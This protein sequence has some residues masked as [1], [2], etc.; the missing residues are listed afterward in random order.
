MPYHPAIVCY[1]QTGHQPQSPSSFHDELVIAA[2][3]IATAA[4]PVPAISTT[5]AAATLTAAATAVAVA[6]LAELIQLGPMVASGL[7]PIDDRCG[8]V[9]PSVK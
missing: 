8:D 2:R 9:E 7:M 4:T 6:V 1:P 5:T 3:A